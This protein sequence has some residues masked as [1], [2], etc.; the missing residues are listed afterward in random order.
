MTPEPPRQKARIIKE[1][2]PPKIDLRKTDE[3][4]TFLKNY[5]VV[6]KSENNFIIEHKEIYFSGFIIPRQKERWVDIDKESQV[7]IF[8][9]TKQ[10]AI[11]RLM[12]MFEQSRE[13]KENK[14]PKYHYL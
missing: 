3:R 11:D 5:R 8:M 12:S 14:F 13:A 9:S 6:E 7:N 10:K 4:I 1:N 2:E